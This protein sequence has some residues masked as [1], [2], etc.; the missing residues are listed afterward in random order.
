[1]SAITK[2][3]LTKVTMTWR[4]AHFGAVMSGSLQLPHTSS[5]TTG[6]EKEVIYSSPKGDPLEART[7]C[8]DNGRGPVCTT[9]KITI[10]PF[11]TVSV[12]ANTSVKR[13]CMWVHMLMELMPGPQLPTAVVPMVTYQEL[14]LGSSRVPICLHNLGACSIETPTKTVVGQ[15]APANQM[16]LVVLPVRTSEES[17]SKP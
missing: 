2:G 17:N 7:F 6:V 15:V 9:Q 11:S 4:Q 12:H 5:N 14:H 1:M 10:L 3:E 8:L 13:H 16:T